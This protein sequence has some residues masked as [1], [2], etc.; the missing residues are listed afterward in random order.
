MPENSAAVMLRT[1]DEIDTTELKKG[2]SSR[3]KIN[4]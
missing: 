1:N 3:S 2:K 4:P